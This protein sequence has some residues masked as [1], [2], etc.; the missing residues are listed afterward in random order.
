MPLTQE[1]IDKLKKIHFEEYGEELS[2]QEAWD[3]GTRLV[4][5]FKTIVKHE[6]EQSKAGDK[7]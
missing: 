2:N 5:L 6:F 7:N 4:N 1:A 3:M